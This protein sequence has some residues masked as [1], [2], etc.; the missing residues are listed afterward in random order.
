MS[1]PR[2]SRASRDTGV[3]LSDEPEPRRNEPVR[4]DEQIR[5]PAYKLDP[6]RG[7]KHSDDLGDWLRLVGEYRDRSRDLLLR[8]EMR[9]EPPGR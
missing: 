9:R 1:N 2:N 5:M 3:L 8:G 4:A 6:Q 7:A